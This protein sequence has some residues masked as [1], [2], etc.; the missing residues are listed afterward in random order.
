[1]GSDNS[2][3][4][5]A[6]SY[7]DKIMKKTYVAKTDLLKVKNQFKQLVDNDLI[8]KKYLNKITNIAS[9]AKGK[10]SV[11]ILK[12]FYAEFKALAA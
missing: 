10:N 4:K 11:T 5:N 2:F 1:M 7:L 3:M 8:D 12:D 9:N 6:T